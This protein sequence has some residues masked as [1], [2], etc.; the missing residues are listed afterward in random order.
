MVAALNMK[1]AHDSVLA[2]G[3]LMCLYYNRY[4]HHIYATSMVSITETH[5]HSFV[6]VTP[7]GF[8]PQKGSSTC[9]GSMLTCEGVMCLFHEHLEI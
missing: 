2:S 1:M 4:R 8:C 6:M 7:R 5:V 3:G 9:N